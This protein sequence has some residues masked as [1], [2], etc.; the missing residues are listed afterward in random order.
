M[1]HLDQ[2]ECESA[3]YLAEQ[4]KIVGRFAN[5]NEID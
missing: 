2:L 1:E 4:A 5:S 3:P